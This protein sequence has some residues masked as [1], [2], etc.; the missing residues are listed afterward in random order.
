VLV[1]KS[2]KS[3]FPYFTYTGRTIKGKPGDT[4]NLLVEHGSR[5]ITAKT[6]IPEIS[7]IDSCWFEIVNSD[8]SLATIWLRFND[9][10]INTTNYYRI[11]AKSDEQNHFVPSLFPN[12]SDENLSTSNPE[13]PVY[14]KLDNQFIN[15]PVIYFNP[16]IGY[17]LKIQ[18]MTSEVFDIWG[19]YQN[20]S[21]NAANPYA[22]SKINVKSNI[23]GDGIGI[24]AGYG[25]STYILN[26]Q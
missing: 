2:D 8:D 14:Q 17:T 15:S 25:V 21:Y 1:L 22:E 7:V 18:T 19:S 11:L 24:W 16:Y 6:K 13:L 23:S 10:D 26:K 9:P 4:Y 12:Y 20:E 5:T 3:K